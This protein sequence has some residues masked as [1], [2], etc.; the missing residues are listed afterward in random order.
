[1]KTATPLIWAFHTQRPIFLYM[2]PCTQPT[3]MFR[4]R[5]RRIWLEAQRQVDSF[6]SGLN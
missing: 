5:V 2:F 3:T 4:R 6:S 1:M